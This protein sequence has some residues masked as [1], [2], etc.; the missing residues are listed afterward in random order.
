MVGE[1]RDGRGEFYDQETFQ[2]RS[3]YVRF[4]WSGMTSTS[5]RWEQAFSADGGRTWE[6]NWIMEFTR[7]LAVLELR[8][9]TLHPGAR[10]TLVDLFDE[11]FVES[12]EALGSWVLGQFRDL[13]D[14]NRFAWV[15]GF[16][17]GPRSFRC[18]TR[19]APRSS[20]VS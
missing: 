13:G 10:D 20:H 16:D 8:Q 17:S 19:R 4:I 14:S 9:Y 18:S 5:C 12:Q 6:T 3:I 11:H 2:G 7:D 15:R 1:F